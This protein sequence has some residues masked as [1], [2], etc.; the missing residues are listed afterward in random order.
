M[1]SNSIKPLLLLLI[2]LLLA[3]CAKP[4]PPEKM[5]YAGEWL[6]KEMYLLILEDGTVSY[7]RLKGGGTVEVN[8]PI[9]E[10]Q[11]DDFVVGFAFIKTTFVVERPPY[12]EKGIWKMVVDGV[13]LT[14]S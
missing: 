13:E 8:G 5:E 12:Q 7:K 11:G 6:S 1:R 9:Q 2:A 4:L 3:S 10:F 14:R